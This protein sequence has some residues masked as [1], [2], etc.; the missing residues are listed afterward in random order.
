[1]KLLGTVRAKKSPRVTAM[2]VVAL[3]V[4][5]VSL[6]TPVVLPAECHAQTRRAV[7]PTAR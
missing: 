4:V 1:M 2:A 7:P 3:A 6:A 5:G